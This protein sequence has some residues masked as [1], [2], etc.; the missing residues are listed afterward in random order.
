M[1]VIPR[2]SIALF[3]YILI[4]SMLI[5]FKPAIMFDAE[6]NIK[7]SG[8]GLKYG[9]SPFSPAIVFPLLAILCYLFSCV[10]SL[11]VV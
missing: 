2:W 6:G 10:F 7:T 1:I 11:A 3:V 8:T 9:S 4:V 5:I